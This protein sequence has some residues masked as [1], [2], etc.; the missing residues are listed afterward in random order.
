MSNHSSGS[1]RS[2]GLLNLEQ[3]R[4]RAKDLLKSYQAQELG[5]LKRFQTYHPKAKVLQV[6]DHCA[7]SPT[8]SDAQ[9]VIAREYGLSSWPKLKAHI[10][11][12]A[13]AARAI[14]SGDAIAL[15]GDIS[16]LHLRCG[17]DIQ[18]R[19]MIA[20]FLG[21]FLEFADPFCQGP[22]TSE[23][24]LS[25]FLERR[26]EF[27]AN[28]YGIALN[29]ARQR[30]TQEYARLGQSHAY[31]RVVLWFE[32]D[33]YDQLILAYVL[34]QYCQTQGPAQLELICVNQFPGVERFLG[35]GQ[36]S[37]EGLRLLWDTRRS[38]TP[39]QLELG[40]AVWQALTASSPMALVKLMKTGTVAIPTMAAALRR[41]LQELPWIEDGL[42]LT[43]RLTLQILADYGPSAAGR[44]FTTLTQE[45]EPIPYLGD[46]MYWRVLRELS[47]PPNPL[48]AVLSDPTPESWPKR[49]LTL[50]QLGQ[51]VLSGQAHR[52]H[53]SAINRWVGGVRLLSG[54]ALW[55][56]DESRDRTVLQGYV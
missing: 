1:P 26:V 2:V 28:A 16:T 40:K 6:F 55:C 47:Q 8:L 31:P 56:W 52:L 18:Q 12:M 36:L 54:E 43:E 45:R 13:V 21:D 50:T 23:T 46:T 17:S 39:K 34:R 11:H 38:V 9:L 41:H 25:L 35:L 37:P 14:A 30:L 32:H 51:D 20:G 53:T 22:V 19:L 24:D 48:I 44:V 33:A 7:F 4:K 10:D 3:Q 27:I 5:A 15:D 49:Q 42:S 29:D